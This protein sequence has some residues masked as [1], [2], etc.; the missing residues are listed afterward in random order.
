MQKY[1]INSYNYV[2][3]LDLDYRKLNLTYQ[4]KILHIING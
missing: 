4:S 2:M 1:P 3:D